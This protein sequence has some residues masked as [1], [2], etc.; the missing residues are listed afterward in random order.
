MVDASKKILVVGAG[1]AG[2]A[3]CYWLKSFGFSPHLIERSQTLR[4][5]GYAVDIRGI[6]IDVVK[7]M[8]IFEKICDNRTTVNRCRHVD[9]SGETLHIEEGEQSGFRQG[10]EVEIVRGDLIEILMQTME[11]IPC[12]FNRTVENIQQHDDG[13][14]VTFN[15]NQSERY[16]LIIGTDGLH[17]PTRHMI[18]PDD[19]HTL[20][21]LGSYISVFSIPNYLDLSHEAVM[22]EHDQKLAHV[23]SDK[24]PDTALTEFMFR[25]K[26][27][28]NDFRDGSEAKRFLRQT[29]ENLGWDVNKLLEFMEQADD[30]Y[31]DS[32]SQVKMRTWTKGRVA[33]V[34]DAGYCA[35]PLSGQGTSLALVGAYVL[36]G[37]LMLSDGDYSQAFDNYNEILRPFVE[38]NQ[39]FGEWSSQNFLM[40]EQLDKAAAEARTSAIM[41]KLALAANAIKLPEYI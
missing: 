29:Y 13:V 12:G 1:I 20:K 37:E 11:E 31:F 23:V 14:E 38:A 17:S 18:F 21:N 33:L 9:Q 6:A 2:P 24:D 19:A 25:S 5:G 28:I 22:F 4:T 39:S 10:E 3:V 34:G 7:K 32:I 36:A 26:H 16:D 35:S 27:P 30:F 41:Q 15:N 40:P 8:G